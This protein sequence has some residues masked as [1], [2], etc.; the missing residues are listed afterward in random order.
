MAAGPGA[1]TD[2]IASIV[3]GLW[4]VT[5]SHGDGFQP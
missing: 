4:G 2:A 3:A 5:A 1:G